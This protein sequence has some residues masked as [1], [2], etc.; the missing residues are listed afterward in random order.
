MFMVA[1]RAVADQVTQAELDSGLLYPPQSNILETEVAVAV[2][3]AETIFARR[4]GRRREAERRAGIRR[5]PT[6]QARVP[7][8]AVTEATGQQVNVHSIESG[9]T[10]GTRI[11]GV[12]GESPVWL[13]V[14]HSVEVRLFFPKQ[15]VNEQAAAQVWHWSARKQEWKGTG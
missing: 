4:P 7:D 2:K 14:A 8:P 9:A 10:L 1:A 6:L 13:V 15:Q 12:R 3:V 11:E 5:S